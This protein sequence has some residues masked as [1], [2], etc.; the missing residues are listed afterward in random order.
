MSEILI[1]LS[2]VTTNGY[3]WQCNI[4]YNVIILQTN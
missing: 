1:T 2:Y 4:S 3:N